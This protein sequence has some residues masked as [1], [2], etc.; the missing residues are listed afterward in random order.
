MKISVIGTLKGLAVAALVAASLA[1]PSAPV[2][3]ACETLNTYFEAAISGGAVL[4]AGTLVLFVVPDGSTATITGTFRGMQDE[5]ASITGTGTLT[6]KVLTGT[7]DITGDVT[8]TG[9]TFSGKLKGSKLKLK[10]ENAIGQKVKVNG[11]G[12]GGGRTF[13]TA[14]IDGEP[15]SADADGVYAEWYDLYRQLQVNGTRVDGPVA[16]SVIGLG[17]LDTGLH[18][19][20]TY[21]L[22]QSSSLVGIGAYNHADENGTPSLYM[23]DSQNTG[24]M[25]ICSFDTKRGAIAGTFYF[26]AAPIG[27]GTPVSVTEGSFRMPVRIAKQQAP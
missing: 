8:A 12:P 4:P 27:G 13:V 5:T 24:S 6:G 22:G 19:P 26:T 15:W 16:Y 21:P 14:L 23:T 20:Y 7:F 10:V 1:S 25:T 3:A 18:F 2:Q 17:I 11:V 9:L